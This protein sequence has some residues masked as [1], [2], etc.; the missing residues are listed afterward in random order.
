MRSLKGFR[1]PA[2]SRGAYKLQ[3]LMLTPL[4]R[5]FLRVG[6]PFGTV[7]LGVGLYLA[8]QERRDALIL[9]AADI[10]RQIED[11][12]EFMVNLMSITGA[13]AE[14]AED[15]REII[16]IDFPVTS[17]DLDLEQIRARAEELDAVARARV[18]VR[19]GGVLEIEVAE[20]EPAVVWRMERGLELLDAEGHRVASLTRRT[21]RPELPLLAG[22]GAYLAV[23]EALTLLTTAE[24]IAP[25]IR[26]LLRVGER[27]WDLVLDRN[28]RILLPEAAPVAALERVL[29][30]DEAQG[31]LGRDLTVVDMRN[32]AR[33]TLRL[34]QEASE[35]FRETRFDLTGSQTE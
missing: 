20:R 25:R 16:P 31:L 27:R 28:Q 23:P 22:D 12:P 21:D 15:I 9:G 6:L 14:V 5:L 33:P 32:P 18:R 13:S 8:D 17:F 11:R 30:L 35:T 10:R 26:G 1:D 19:T 4:F 2:P 24:M 29:A 3:R 7:A 34:S